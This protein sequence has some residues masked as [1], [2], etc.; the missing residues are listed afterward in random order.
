MEQITKHYSSYATW[1][2]VTRRFNR[3]SR[4]MAAE[5]WHLQSQSS[6][7]KAWGFAKHNI[8][9]TYTRGEVFPMQ[10]NDQPPADPPS[11]PSSYPVY[12]APPPPPQ[13]SRRPGRATRFQ[14]WYREQPLFMKVLVWIGVLFVAAAAITGV[15]QGIQESFAPTSTPT[16]SQATS[17]PTPTPTSSRA[18]STPTQVP[19]PKPTA[20]PAPSF[21]HFGDGTFV[22]GKDIKPGT[23][24]TRTGSPGCYFARLSGFGGTVGDI[25]SNAN[26]DNPA[27]VTIAAS[28]KGFQSTNCG[29]WTKDLSAITTSKTS[30]SDGM[31]I[32][33]P[34]IEPGTYK[35]GG[36]QGCYYARLSGF[37]GTVDDIISNANTDTAAIVTISASD[38]GFQSD[39]CGTWTR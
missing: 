8:V 27:I 25:I 26:T 12:P 10:S 21:A 38:K 11:Q 3:D 4:K 24:R 29:T 33:G 16:S 30:F 22:V 6:S 15:V 35:S 39:S 31:Y 37:G 36:Q 28:D 32:I 19:T 20:K 13:P 34:D 5:G 14:S 2:G 7:Y 23:Y 9:A 18:T 1:R 17:A